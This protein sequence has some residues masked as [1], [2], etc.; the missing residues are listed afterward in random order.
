MV[1]RKRRDLKII[2]SS[3]TLETE[4]FSKFFDSA[5]V[6]EIEGKVYPV[7]LIYEP[8]INYMDVI[9]RT[10]LKLHCQN[11]YG[12]GTYPINFVGQN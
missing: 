4:K 2:V 7:K 5:P 12:T 3:A 9:T 1:A 6:I 8:C 10:V 11:E